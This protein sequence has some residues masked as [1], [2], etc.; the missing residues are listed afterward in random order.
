MIKLLLIFLSFSVFAK[1]EIAVIDTGVGIHQKKYLCKNGSISWER[2]AYDLNGHGSNVI[3][4]ITKKMDT[5]KYCIVSYKFW[6]ASYK[7][8]DTINFVNKALENAIKRKVAVINMSLYGAFYSTPEKK[9]IEKALDMGIAIVVAAGNDGYNLDVACIS[10]PACYKFSHKNFYV[11][12][13]KE[14]KFSNYGAVVD[15]YENG[16]KQGELKLSGTSQA[17]ANFTA[18]LISE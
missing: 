11:I 4:L 12:G 2:T 7:S 10:F 14:E 1:I 13:A 8:E 3:E 5:N 17:A 18:K 16:T 9:L 15:S 6:D